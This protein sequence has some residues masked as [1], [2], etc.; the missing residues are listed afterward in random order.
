MTKSFA[1][2]SLGNVFTKILIYPINFISSI[3]IARYLGAEDRGVYAFIVLIN[4]FILPLIMLGFGN[5]ITYMISAKKFEIKKI[6]FTVIIYGFFLGLLSAIII[7]TAWYFGLLGQTAGKISKLQISLVA[8]ALILATP[9][10]FISRILLGNS[11]FTIIN[12]LDIFQNIFQPILL[13]FLCYGLSLRITGTAL[14]VA[15][16]SAIMLFT[17]FIIAYKKY[18]PLF[19]FNNSFFKECFAYGLKGWPA[20]VSTR[21]NAR[22]DQMLLGFFAPAK[23][24]GLYSIAVTLSELLWIIPD[25]V[26]VVLFTKLA[27]MDNLNEKTKLMELIHRLLFWVLIALSVG[28]ALVVSYIIIPYGYG[29]EYQDSVILFL[30]LL[31]GTVGYISAKVITK[32]LSGSGQIGL[33]SMSITIGAITTSILYFVLVPHYHSFGAASAS[34]FGYIFTS[35]ICILIYHKNIT[36]FNFKSFFQIDMSDIKLVKNKFIKK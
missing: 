25:A 3:I 1:R 13:L 21:A 33:T 5:G 22:L 20:D 31:P 12:K 2:N 18:A 7:F 27:G 29:S 11:Q 34:S 6:F 15:S 10:F 9:Q 30:L 17:N 23:E 16:L 14:A 32:I 35:L 36:I 24:L 4:S 19:I 28:W 26:G 8:L